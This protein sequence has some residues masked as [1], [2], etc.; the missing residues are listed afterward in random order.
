MKK[1]KKVT[2]LLLS[3]IMIFTLA[4]CSTPAADAPVAD[5]PVTEAPEA[6]TPVDDT[7]Y[8]LSLGH[9]WSGTSE[10]E[11]ELVQRW[12]KEVDEATNG[13]VKITSYPGNVLTAAPDNY[14]G[15]VDGIQDIG[16]CVYGYSAGRFPVVE[17]FTLPGLSSFK[18]SAAAS[19]AMTDAI[20]TLDPVELHDT[21]HLFSFSTGASALLSSVPVRVLEDYKGLSLGVTQAERARMLELFG[22]TP[23]SLPVPEWYDS[24]QKKL[25]LGGI[26]SPEALAGGN[27]LGD[28]TGDYITNSG[29]FACS[30]IYC[31]M[32]KDKFDSLP[33]EYQEVLKGLPSYFAEAWDGLATKGIVHTKTIRDVEIITLS[34]EEEDRWRETMAPIIDDNLNM[35]EERG[36]DGEHI[37]KVVREMEE[38]WNSEF[39]HSLRDMIEA[40]V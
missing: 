4:A 1:V 28:V 6:T 14:Q 21:A 29:L 40:V 30:M 7:V 22:A 26:M 33:A 5:A 12:I 18:N 27:R 10:V 23:V 39:P 2:V 25:I 11:L 19:Y 16:I 20:E 32:N 13:H 34:Q 9:Q 17:A 36:L 35:L 8:E 31:T 24:L 37:H 38:K 3:V 15:V